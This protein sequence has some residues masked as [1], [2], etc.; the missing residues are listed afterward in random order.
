MV[1]ARTPTIAKIKNEASENDARALLYIA[2]CDVCDFFNVGK[3]MTDTQVAFTIDLIIERYWYLKLEE[4]KYCF[5][6]AM[7]AERLF[8]R[9]DGNIILGWLQAYDNERT[10]A[11]ALL[12]HNEAMEAANAPVDNPDAVS[13][14]EYRRMLRERAD[15]GD[16]EAAERLADMEANPKMTSALRSRE[17]KQKR[18][19]EFRLW[20]EEYNKTKK[21]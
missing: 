18:E 17:E 1:A 14:A 15:N 9:L 2:I 8:D 7:G 21:L 5:R 13:F 3:T 4:I 20:R 11:A 19:A 12:S 16:K 6:R 10:E